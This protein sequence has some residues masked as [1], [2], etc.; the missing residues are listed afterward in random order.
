MFT[1]IV[2]CEGEGHLNAQSCLLEGLG[3]GSGQRGVSVKLV[4]PD[5]IQ[6]SLFPGQVGGYGIGGCGQT[7]APPPSQVIA[8]E[9][10]NNIHSRTLMASKIYDQ[11]SVSR[12]LSL[13]I[14][15]SHTY[16]GCNTSSTNKATIG[17]LW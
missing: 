2:V 1:G 14:T 13:S 6:C 5:N 3:G 4:L 11:V 15:H 16:T 7:A 8:V 10:I 12:S 9:G 17:Y